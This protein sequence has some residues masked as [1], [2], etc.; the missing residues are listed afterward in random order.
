M[1]SMQIAAGSQNANFKWI[2]LQYPSL[3]GTYHTTNAQRRDR[4]RP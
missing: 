2:L 3:V 1:I 4:R